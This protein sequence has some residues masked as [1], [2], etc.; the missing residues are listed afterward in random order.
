MHI[1]YSLSRSTISHSS[2]IFLGQLADQRPVSWLLILEV[3]D[4]ISHRAEAGTT[5]GTANFACEGPKSMAYYIAESSLKL[6]H[7]TKYPC[8]Y[9]CYASYICLINHTLL[10][11]VELRHRAKNSVDLDQTSEHVLINEC[12]NNV[13][14]LSQ[15]KSSL[16]LSYYKSNVRFLKKKNCHD[17]WC[18]PLV[19]N[20]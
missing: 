12:L 13:T 14:S 11:P 17:R 15:L 5:K 16:N 19:I 2:L 7:Q 8:I 10:L 3:K 1:S 9:T 4:T 6:F 18:S 20:F